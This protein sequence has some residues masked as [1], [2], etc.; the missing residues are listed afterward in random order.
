MPHQK[1]K[2]KKIPASK[3]LQQKIGTGHISPLAIERAEKTIKENSVDF[4]PV[5]LEFLERLDK[6]L[7]NVDE[8]SDIQQQK[9]SII[10]PVMELKANAKIFHYELVGNLANIMLNFV[11]A[12]ETLDKDAIAIV[13]G[14]HD[15]LKLILTNKMTGNGGENGKTMIAELN[16]ACNRYYKKRQ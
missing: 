10:K 1:S 8:N 6:A 15:S 5:G 16:D 3:E 4:S 2:H 14:H 9:V 7:N 11:E 12:I 13:R